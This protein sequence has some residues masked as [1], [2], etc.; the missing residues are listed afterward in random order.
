MKSIIIPLALLLSIPVMARDTGTG[1]SDTLRRDVK[2]IHLQ[3][4]ET[5]R[6]VKKSE[7]LSAPIHRHIYQR[8]QNPRFRGH[9]SGFNLGFADFGDYDIVPG[10][11][12]FMDL[13][14]KNSLAIQHVPIQYA[15]E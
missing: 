1:T 2:E 8:S 5:S 9:W 11:S 6:Q 15:S 10:G 14:R 12:P 13:Q 4:R 7:I 3:D